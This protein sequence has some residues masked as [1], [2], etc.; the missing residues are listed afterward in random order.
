MNLS[1]LLRL[2]QQGDPEAAAYLNDPNSRP[3]IGRSRPPMFPAPPRATLAPD[4]MRLPLPRIQGGAMPERQRI[5]A[6][7]LQR[8]PL[9]YGPSAA[10]ANTVTPRPPQFPAMTPAPTVRFRDAMEPVGPEMVDNA[11]PPPAPDAYFSAPT[12][13]LG[14]PN[15]TEALTPAHMGTRRDFAFTGRYLGGDRGKRE[16]WAQVPQPPQSAYQDIPARDVGADDDAAWNA[17][18][19]RVQAEMSRQ[20]DP[21]SMRQIAQDELAPYR[22]RSERDRLIADARARHG[23]RYSRR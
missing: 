15:A 12:G 3:E 13:R 16:S 19:A 4:G 20:R 17:A 18:Q 11:P 14:P 23:G 5:V 1:D 8:Y 7:P 6:N 2:L 22:A 21:T 9:V 10:D